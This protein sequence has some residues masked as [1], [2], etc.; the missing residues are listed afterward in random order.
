MNKKT[1]QIETFRKKFFELVKTNYYHEK[2]ISFME[3]ILLNVVLGVNE[4]LRNMKL[5]FVFVKDFE[6]S[7]AMQ[8]EEQNDSIVK[9]GTY[10]NKNMK[11]IIS[12]M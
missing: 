10:L 2:K 1:L 6:E 5:D 7:F 12:E 9:I 11:G 4:I 3:E 8:F